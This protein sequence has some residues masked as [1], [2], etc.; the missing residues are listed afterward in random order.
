VI[1]VTGFSAG[2]MGRDEAADSVDLVLRKPVQRSEL[3]RAI[4]SVMEPRASLM[5]LEAPQR[6]A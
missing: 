4:V 6:A 1:L 3:R 2:T 5:A